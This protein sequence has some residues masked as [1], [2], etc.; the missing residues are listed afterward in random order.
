MRFSRDEID[1]LESEVDRRLS[2][3]E[4]RAARL[5]GV[6]TDAD[7]DDDPLLASFA[8]ATKSPILGIEEEVEFPLGYRDARGLRFDEATVMAVK[9]KAMHA[10][11]ISRVHITNSQRRKHPLAAGPG[12]P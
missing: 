3:L 6:T 7:T 12:A 4:Q 10:G 8:P 11:E 5:E 2:N 9:I 1:E